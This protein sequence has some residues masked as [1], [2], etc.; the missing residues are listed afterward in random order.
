LEIE[1]RDFEFGVGEEEMMCLLGAYQH[2]FQ[3]SVDEVWHS[4]VA[5]IALDHGF[6]HRGLI[7]DA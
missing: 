5:G 3:K 4:V 6:A 1:L 7:R 2:V